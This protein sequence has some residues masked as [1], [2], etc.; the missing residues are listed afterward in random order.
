MV[1]KKCATVGV[2]CSGLYLEV[3]IPFSS[4]LKPLL[5]PWGRISGLGEGSLHWKKTLI[6]SIGAPEI[7][8]VSLFQDMF[9]Q[10]RPFLD[11][12]LLSPPT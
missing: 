4:R 10:A 11:P 3:K 2:D 7:G 8:T 9:A 1:Y 5:I 12:K 6:L